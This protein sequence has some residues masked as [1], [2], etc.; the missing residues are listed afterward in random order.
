MQYKSKVEQPKKTI[1]MIALD[2]PPCQSAGVQRTLKFAEYLAELG[3]QPIVLT[4]NEDV[5][6]NVDKQQQIPDEIKVYRCHSY[7]SSVDFAYKGKYFGWSKIPDRWWSWA[8]NAIPM[9]K[10]LI[11][12]YK[13]SVIWSTYPVS[14]AHYIGYK[15]HQHS[16]IPWIADYRDP[17]QCRY[18]SNV[19]RYSFVAKWIER[20]AIENACKAIFTTEK[21]AQMYQKLY[22]NEL[23][24]K[25]AVIENGYDEANF[26]NLPVIA[27]KETEKFVLLHSGSIYS[28][29][30]DPS[31]L[32]LAL[33]E[34]KQENKLS[35]E[36]F[37]LMFR[38][39]VCTEKHSKTIKKL[40][41]EDIVTFTQNIPYKE[42]LIEMMQADCL[43]ILQGALFNNQ[44]PSKAYEYIRTGKPIMALTGVGGATEGL[45]EKVTTGY[46][47]ASAKELKKELAVILTNKSRK[48]D[49]FDTQKFSRYTRTKELHDLL[50]VIKP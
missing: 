21:A 45:L 1:L 27:V 32:F 9:G 6:R 5:Y 14:T 17:L 50:T 36:N 18:D 35:Q 37:I 42:S 8:I 12:K 24:S 28:E 22:P 34:L 15:L 33:S 41:I 4:V 2:F 23:L 30:R 26:E 20:K 11:S 40:A 3:W 44:I 46:G 39:G 13:P 10:S 19:E 47:A 29:G 48:S 49:D 31:E 7:D 43:L 25:F 38:G 16:G